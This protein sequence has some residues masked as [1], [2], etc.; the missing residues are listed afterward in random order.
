MALRVKNVAAGYVDAT[1]FHPIRS[2]SDYDPSRL[3]DEKVASREKKRK[4]KIGGWKVTD[5]AKWQGYSNATSTPTSSGR[6]KTKKKAAKK[7]AAKK[8]EKKTAAKKRVAVK[9]NPL[10]VGKWK[11]A[12]VMRTK[13][14]DVKVMLTY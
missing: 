8:T 11:A 10:P 14:G 2:S 1:G 5:T 9:K 13:S 7:T 12:K 4:K 6:K 3:S